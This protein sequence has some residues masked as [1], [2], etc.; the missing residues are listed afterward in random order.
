MT[1]V[2][3]ERI[4]PIKTCRRRK[5]GALIILIGG[6]RLL[7]GAPAKFLP[8][9]GRHNKQSEGK[10]KLLF[11]KIAAGRGEKKGRSPRCISEDHIRV[12]PLLPGGV[13]F[14]ELVENRLLVRGSRV[15]GVRILGI[16]SPAIETQGLFGPMAICRGKNFLLEEPYRTADRRAAP[17]PDWGPAGA[18]TAE[19]EEEILHGESKTHVGRGE[20]RLL[21]GRSEGRKGL[22]CND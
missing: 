10:G 4:F 1:S 20:K 7:L 22:A 14:S 2:K 13:V 18:Y 15:P 12:V 21:T 9:A 11:L 5:K 16:N 17:G 3:E 8:A 19:E 6:S